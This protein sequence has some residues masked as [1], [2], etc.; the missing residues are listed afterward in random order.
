MNGQHNRP[1]AGFTLLEVVLALVLVATLLVSSLLALGRLRRG[2]QLANDRQQA[3][4]LADAL[5]SGWHQS[6][7]G[8]P[9]AAS[10]PIADRAGWWWKTEVVANRIVFGQ[11]QAI[12]RLQIVARSPNSFRETSLA[13]VEVLRP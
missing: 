11:P 7:Q 1:A 9:L 12:V 10:A 2:L 6:P 5:L 13:S 4:T 3:I 8:I